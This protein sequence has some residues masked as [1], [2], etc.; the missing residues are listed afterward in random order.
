MFWKKTRII[1]GIRKELSG[2]FS[3]LLQAAVCVC[4]NNAGA[5]VICSTHVHLDHHN[6]IEVIV[7]SGSSVEV[8]KLA[9]RLISVR[10]VKH[11]QLSCTAA[12]T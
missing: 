1:Q 8:R 12:Q 11:G 4:R 5:S 3:L 9:N 2:H 6:C 7:V 10:G